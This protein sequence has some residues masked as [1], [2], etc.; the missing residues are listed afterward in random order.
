MVSKEKPRK[1]PRTVPAI[2]KDHYKT[3]RFP[4]GIME[5][6]QE[7]GGQLYGIASARAATAGGHVLSPGSV[8]VLGLFEGSTA[9]YS[10]K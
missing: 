4:L 1:A 2:S 9:V 8:S 6:S 3:P 5:G 10:K 7:L